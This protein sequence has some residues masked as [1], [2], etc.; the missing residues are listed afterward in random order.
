M[1]DRVWWSKW[2]REICNKVLIWS[3]EVFY[4]ITKNLLFAE[5]LYLKQRVDKEIYF[6]KDKNILRKK[7]T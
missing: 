7:D 1:R 6:K 3:T 2:Y 5:A 4:R